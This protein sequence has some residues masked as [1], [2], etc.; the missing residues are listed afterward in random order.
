[1]NTTRSVSIY[2]NQT[3]FSRASL[4]GLEEQPEAIALNSLREKS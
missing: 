1:M 2:N 3:V 4:K